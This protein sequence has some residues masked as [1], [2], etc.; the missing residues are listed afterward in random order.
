MSGCMKNPPSSA[1]PRIREQRPQISVGP[2]T[3]DNTEFFTDET[4]IP[5]S[6]MFK[7]GEERTEALQ[8]IAE[9]VD[10]ATGQTSKTVITPAENNE[11]RVLFS[12]VPESPKTPETEI[13]ETELPYNLETEH[14]ITEESYPVDQVTEAIPDT[15]ANEPNNDNANDIP[16]L[17]I[18]T[19]SRIDDFKLFCSTGSR[20]ISMYKNGPGYGVFRYLT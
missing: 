10:S 19:F 3:A 8:K 20:D 12:S 18:Y 6:N 1:N 15:R 17:E 2:G 16:C 14:Q 4:L 13:N 5:L 11:A 9:A 7:G